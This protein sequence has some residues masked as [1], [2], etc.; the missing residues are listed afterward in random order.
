LIIPISW[1]IQS[2]AIPISWK[3]HSCGVE[4]DHGEPN[5][6]I[7]ITIPGDYAS[8]GMDAKRNP[9]SFILPA[10]FW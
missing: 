5:R 6:Y 8:E 1:K 2:F 10:N 7:F 9:L 3:I 4:L